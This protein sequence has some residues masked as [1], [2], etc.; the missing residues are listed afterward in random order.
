[1]TAVRKPGRSHIANSTIRPT[2]RR[3]LA[4]VGDADDHGRG[5]RAR[6]RVSRMPS[7]TAMTTTK[8]AE[9]KVSLTC[10]QICCQI[11]DQASALSSTESSVAVACQ[12]A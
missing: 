1:M 4:G 3:R 2:D 5:G 11:V 9:T 12:T 7:G 6:P 10:S 8:K